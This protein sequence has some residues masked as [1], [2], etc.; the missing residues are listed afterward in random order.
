MIEKKSK[1]QKQTS[2]KISSL[3]LAPSS[4]FI[5]GGG[6]EEADEKNTI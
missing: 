4:Y 2:N 6:E 5:L 3:Y 1:E